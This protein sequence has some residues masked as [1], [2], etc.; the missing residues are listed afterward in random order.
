MVN[1]FRRTLAWH[2]ARLPGGRVALALQYGHLRASTVTDGYA[3]RARDGLRRILDI[4]TAR[5]MAD[6]LDTVADRLHRGEHVSGPA[7]RRL[8]GAAT[9]AQFRFEGM[10]LHP[11]RPRTARS[12]EFHVY[13]NPEA[14]LTCNYD[15]AKALC[16]PDRTHP[17]GRSKSPAIDRCD[18]ACANI[19]R[20]DTHIAALRNEI[21]RLREEIVEPA[22]P[23][24]LRERLGQ[25]AAHLDEL[26][27]QHGR[28]HITNREETDVDR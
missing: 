2:I 24:P 11:S 7:A 5:A 20:T 26:V 16:H 6:Y 3:G 17:S 12:P 21:A 22:T 9:G 1:R 13:D 15:P 8:I 25:R 28:T 18:P 19:A 4:E 10:F 23:M 27:D 14:F